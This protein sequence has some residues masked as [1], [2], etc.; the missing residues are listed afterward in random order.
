VRCGGIEA[1]LFPTAAQL[2]AF[3]TAAARADVP[4]K[5]TAGLHH[6]VRYP[7][8]K[9]GFTHHGFLNILVA[10]ARAVGGAE[11]AEV[12]AALLIDDAAQ[13]A[14][15]ARDLPAATVDLARRRFLAYGSC[16]TSEPVADLVEL[17]LIG[18]TSH[19]LGR[20]SRRLGL[21]RGE[22]PLRGLLGW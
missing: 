22:P 10:I 15:A 14:A 11:Q 1:H 16:S 2:A 18:R 17:G 21:P 6:A 13:L 5:A 19:E 7:D 20:R 4:F 12:E 9:M 3:L 8:P